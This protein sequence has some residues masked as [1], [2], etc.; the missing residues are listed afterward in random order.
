MLATTI[1]AQFPIDLKPALHDWEIGHRCAKLGAE[2]R[3]A[4]HERHDQLIRSSAELLHNGG[5][6]RLVT[7]VYDLVARA[8]YLAF[9]VDIIDAQGQAFSLTYKSPEDAVMFLVGSYDG[10]AP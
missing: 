7:G 8:H 3:S 10:S 4:S 9:V 6:L 2:C 1:Q 5:K